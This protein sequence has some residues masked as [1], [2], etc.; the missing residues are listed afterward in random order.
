MLPQLH[1]AML[2]QTVSDT[3]SGSMDEALI[4]LSCVFRQFY[5]LVPAVDMAFNALRAHLFLPLS[6]HNRMEN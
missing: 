1:S 6:S 3:D 5:W 4:S 2:S